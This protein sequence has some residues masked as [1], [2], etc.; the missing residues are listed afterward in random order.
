M[1]KVGALYAIMA[2]VIALIAL[3]FLSGVWVS[4]STE[5]VEYRVI[6][7]LDN[8]VEI[9]EYGE[10]VIVSAVVKDSDDAF[11]VLF[12]Y[13]RGN[14]EN[15]VKIGM[16]A[17]VMSRVEN[18]EVNMSFILPGGYGPENI[19]EPEDREISTGELPARKLATITFRGNIDHSRYME[20]Q[21]ILEDE[22]KKNNIS[23]KGELFLMRYDPPWVPSVLKR[24]EIGVEVE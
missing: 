16:T 5:Q 6:E 7:K 10:Q 21:N 11:G 17:P 15:K 12:R 23:T 8:D 24:N 9:R 1:N 4:M 2:A 20:H 13:I 19:P 22:L 18:G 14:N 3:W